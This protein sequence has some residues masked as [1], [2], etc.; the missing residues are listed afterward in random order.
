MASS[1]DSQASAEIEFKTANP[2]DLTA[3]HKWL[4]SQQPRLDA[5]QGPQAHSS[6][7]RWLARWR[8]PRAVSGELGVVEV[9][10]LLASSSVLSAAIKTLPE[11]IRSRR[12]GIRIEAT[13][14]GQKVIVDATNV[15]EVLPV[16]KKLIDDGH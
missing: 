10:T 11:F 8:R 15:E 14:R 16:L 9:L 2:A 5:R 12:S 1:E 13:A 7:R 6:R 3:L 4:I